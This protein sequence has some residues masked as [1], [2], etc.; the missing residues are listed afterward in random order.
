MF[1]ICWEEPRVKRIN[2]LAQSSQDLRVDS[3]NVDETEV[4]SGILPEKAQEH[5]MDSQRNI[6]SCRNEMGTLVLKTND[7][8][9]SQANPLGTGII[10]MES[11][12]LLQARLGHNATETFA[13]LQQAYGDSVLSRAQVFRW[14]KAFSEGGESIEDESRNRRPSVSK[15]TEGR[16]SP[17]RSSLDNK[18]DL[19]QNGSENPFSVNHFLPSKNIPVA[20][21]PPYSPALSPC[22]FLL[23]PKLRNHLKGHH[24][25]TLENIQTA[26]TV[27]L[28]AIPIFEFHQSYEEWKTW[29]VERGKFYDPVRSL[30][31]SKNQEINRLQLAVKLPWAIF[32]ESVDILS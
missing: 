15:T 16:Y 1:W 23:F 28:K 2:S 6:T 8:K 20:P 3:G 30:L 21:Q 24:F 13:K 22:D 14:F 27:Q 4:L 25:G 11:L 7:S 18:K 31:K 17:F 10:E 5:I 12:H 32:F 29:E 9:K 19:R 26:V